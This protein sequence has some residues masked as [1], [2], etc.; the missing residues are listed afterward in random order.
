[1]KGHEKSTCF[2]R[3]CLIFNGAVSETRTRDP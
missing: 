3:K 2:Y 1:M